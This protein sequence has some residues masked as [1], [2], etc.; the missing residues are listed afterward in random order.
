MESAAFSDA[1]LLKILKEFFKK[2]C[3]KKKGKYYVRGVELDGAVANYYIET[4]KM[5]EEELNKK[6]GPDPDKVQTIVSNMITVID[7]AAAY[8]DDASKDH[9]KDMITFEVTEIDFS[10]ACLFL[11]GITKVTSRYESAEAQSENMKRMDALET[12]MVFG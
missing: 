3:R 11:D 6:P 7:N 10:R 1:E 12:P 2:F 8:F 9:K 4:M 5:A